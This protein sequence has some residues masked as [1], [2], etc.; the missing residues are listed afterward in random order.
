MDLEERLVL[1]C[2]G[3]KIE[4]QDKL[5]CSEVGGQSPTTIL[6]ITLV[7]IFHPSIHPSIRPSIHI[8]FYHDLVKGMN[9]G[10]LSMTVYWPR[11]LCIDV[12]V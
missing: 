3:A 2:N 9:N 12:L 5:L 8:H 6:A 1:F 10:T 4:I 11:I 7:Q